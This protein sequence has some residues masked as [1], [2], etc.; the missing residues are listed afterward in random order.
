M[1]GSCMGI[2]PVSSRTVTVQIVL[3]P[4]IGAYSSLSMIRKPAVARGSHGG[5]IRLVFIEDRPRGSFRRRFLKVSC[6]GCWKYWSFSNIVLQPRASST[7]PTMTSPT[8]PSAW[9]C[10]IETVLIDLMLMKERRE[11][12]RRVA[13][14]IVYGCLAQEYA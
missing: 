1:I 13:P 4:D 11:I 7:P 9:H 5:K 14:G 2:I 3:E 12:R 8:S 6:S 10:T